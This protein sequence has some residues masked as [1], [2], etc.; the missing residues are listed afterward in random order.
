MFG[1]GFVS[2]ASGSGMAGY[3][4]GGYATD[5]VAT[6]DKLTYSTDTTAA[7]TS[8]NLSQARY[9]LAGVNGS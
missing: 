9:I 7:Q 5:S 3:F 8:A 6:A 1:L 4:A 2:F